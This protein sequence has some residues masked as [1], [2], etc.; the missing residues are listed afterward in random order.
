MA[1]SHP[2]PSP[3]PSLTPITPQSQTAYSCD[4]LPAPQNLRIPR[5]IRRRPSRSPSPLPSPPSGDD[6]EPMSA[7]EVVTVEEVRAAERITDAAASPRLEPA[8]LA[9]QPQ[10]PARKL[11]VRHQRMADEGTN[12]D[13]Q[14]VSVLIRI[15]RHSLSLLHILHSWPFI[16]MREW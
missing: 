10:P 12:E 2:P 15:F 1:D 8:D 13:L 14:K 5:T 4:T 11:C 7:F 16:I 6:E 9:H 3:S